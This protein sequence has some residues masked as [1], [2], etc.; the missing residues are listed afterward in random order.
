MD[1]D[2]GEDVKAGSLFDVHQDGRTI[3][4]HEEDPWIRTSFKQRLAE[5]GVE[6]SMPMRKVPCSEVR[7]AL[8]SSA[9]TRD[10]S[11]ECPC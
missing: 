10:V 11:M 5:N 4:Y 3:L 1:E 8:T 6:F 9:T 2:G 7:R